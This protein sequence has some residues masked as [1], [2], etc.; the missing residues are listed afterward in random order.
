MRDALTNGIDPKARPLGLRTWA[1]GALLAGL[2]LAI[3]P[4]AGASTAPAEGQEKLGDGEATT[5]KEM[6]P[7][8]EEVTA[9]DAKMSFKMTP[10]PG[11]TFTMG[12]P[13]DEEGRFEHEGP[14]FQVKV[15]PFWMATHE[16][17]WDEYD[18]FLEQYHVQVEEGYDPV[19][20]EKLFDAVSYPT[21][22]YEEGIDVI[23]NM[24][25]REGRPAVDMTQLAAK[26]YTKWLSKK[27]GRF[28]RLPT[29]AEWEYAARAGTQSAY[30]FGDDMDSLGQY[31]WYLDNSG[32]KYHKPGQKKP[33]PW[34]LYDMHGN[35]AE[36]VIDQYVEDHYAKMA[37]MEQ[38]VSVM[39][40]V[41]WPEREYPKVV[42][43]GSWY[44]FPEDLRSAARRKSTP[45][46]KNR[47]PQLPKSVWWHTE[48]FWVG[49]RVIRPL[50]EPS[51]EVKAKFWRPM[52]EFIRDVMLDVGDKQVQQYFPPEGQQEQ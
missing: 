42:R 27:T 37:Q 14:Q 11:G 1:A 4:Q 21:P 20:E 49:F 7:Y 47:D 40:A 33:N 34:G 19:S 12:S 18:V 8:I 26:Q 2:C 35:V 23:V 15:E 28:Y 50:E 9:G 31:G 46:W 39:E 38:P 29:E 13:S 3:V 17:T 24:G 5:E 52:D 25:P 48:A 10:I 41:V 30:S 22:Q 43:G 16:T 51:K 6:Q 32:E 44:D 45:E 36:W